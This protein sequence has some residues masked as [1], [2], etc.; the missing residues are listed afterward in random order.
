MIE[1]S[2]VATSYAIEALRVFDHLHFRSVMSDAFAPVHDS[3]AKP[4]ARTSAKK[5]APKKAQATK[6]APKV[7]AASSGTGVVDQLTL[8]KPT[9]FSGKAAWFDD[10]YQAGGQKE[11]DRKLFSR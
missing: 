4:H 7:S 9:A 1:D 5:G 11:R 10:F 8:R 2:R 3:V 6:A